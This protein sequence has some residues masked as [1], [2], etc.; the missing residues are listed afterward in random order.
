MTTLDGV[1]RKLEPDMLMIADRDR[2]QA[3]AGVMGGGLSEVSG[4][5]KTVAF[6]S[7]YFKP[8]SVR[9]TSKRLNL[10]TEASSRFERGADISAPVLALAR[11]AALMEQIGAGRTTGP[12]I[13]VY[14]AARGEA[15]IHLRRARLKPL[16]GVE[17]PDADV[18]RILGRLGLSVKPATEDGTLR[19]RPSASISF[20]RST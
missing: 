3:I 9:R 1:E 12:I 5:T 7:A 19:C 15:Q 6:E 10:K 14:P 4:A 13:D 18:L 11:L 17:V 16:L 8:A 20:A 2:G